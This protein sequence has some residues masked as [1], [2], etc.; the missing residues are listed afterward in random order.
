MGHILTRTNSYTLTQQTCTQQT[1]LPRTFV[2]PYTETRVFIITLVGR[3]N[4]LTL[5]YLT[6]VSSYMHISNSTNTSWWFRGIKRV[7]RSDSGQLIQ[8]AFL[9]TYAGTALHHPMYP[10]ADVISRNVSI[11]R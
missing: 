4:Q 5:K 3:R 1:P 7:P 10:L 11:L 6:P 8:R 2:I 9:S